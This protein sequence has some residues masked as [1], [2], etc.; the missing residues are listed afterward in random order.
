MYRLEIDLIREFQRHLSSY[1]SPF[2]IDSIGTEFYYLNGRVDI[3]AI[4]YSR[5]LLAFEGKLMRWRQA[6]N[7]AY[8]STSFADC[9]YVVLPLTTAEV[10]I[11]RQAEFSR[12][13]VGLIGVSSNGIDI[14]L[15]ASPGRKLQPWIGKKALAFLAKKVNGDNYD[16]SRNGAHCSTDLPQ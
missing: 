10:A 4:D 16:P 11:K 7:Q 6:L 9:S 3:V 12:R 15:S 1:A 2:K 14:L 8:R 5:K 13:G